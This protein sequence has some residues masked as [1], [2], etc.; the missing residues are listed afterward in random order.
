MP[1]LVLDFPLCL[2]HSS[3]VGCFGIEQHSFSTEV[4]ATSSFSLWWKGPEREKGH[5]K[6]W[7]LMGFGKGGWAETGESSQ[8]LSLTGTSSGLAGNI[9]ALTWT[10]IWVFLGVS[11]HCC[12]PPVWIVVIPRYPLST[13]PLEINYWTCWAGLSVAYPHVLP[14][15]GLS[16]YVDLWSVLSS[17]T[18]LFHISYSYCPFEDIIYLC[19][20][21]FTVWLC[22]GYLLPQFPWLMK[23]WLCPHRRKRFLSTETEITDIWTMSG[24][25]R[26]FWCNSVE[27]QNYIYRH[28]WVR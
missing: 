10:G 23:S 4:T 6:G 17:S 18:K 19:F 11:S 9:S 15:V 8:L 2:D 28:S 25:S 21:L 3:A 1:L 16:V 20:A 7:I 22:L 27:T 5:E 14:G 13:V 24:V 12:I 26:S